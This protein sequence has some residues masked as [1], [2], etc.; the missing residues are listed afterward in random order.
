MTWDFMACLIFDL[1]K[2]LVKLGVQ[3]FGL[4]KKYIEKH[5]SQIYVHFVFSTFKVLTFVLHVCA[6]VLIMKIS[7]YHQ[8]DN[9][10]FQ[11]MDN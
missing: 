1:L 8:Y 10:D 2:A 7:V 11:Y 9:A 6:N 5:N 4:H 3:V